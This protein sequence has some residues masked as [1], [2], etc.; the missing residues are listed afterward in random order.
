MASNK[1]RWIKNLFGAAEPLVMYGLFQAGA[2]QAVKRGE[3]LSKTADTNTRFEPVGADV[4]GNANIA[5]ANE[6]IK[7]GDRAGYYEIVVP[8]LGDVFEF[9]LD[10]A[11]ATA[12]GAALKSATSETLSA[13][14]SN[15]LAYACGQEHYPQKQGH[16]T[17]DA[18]P[19]SGETIRV[20]STVLVTF[21]EAVSHL[22][23]FQ[24]A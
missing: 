12:V 2:T 4:A 19:D 10:T 22:K 5:I 7:A 18:S 8:R 14:G 9:A 24:V 16:V 1:V 6:E 23:L 20:Q 11:A 21:K 15:A 13:T 17:D 3:I